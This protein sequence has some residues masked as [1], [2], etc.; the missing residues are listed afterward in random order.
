MRCSL[1]KGGLR[2][3]TQAT[4]PNS[5]AK[6]FLQGLSAYLGACVCACAPHACLGPKEA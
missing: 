3:G 1:S 6:A 4:L 5:N 2:Q